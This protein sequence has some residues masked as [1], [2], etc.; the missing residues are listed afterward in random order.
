MTFTR[1]KFFLACAVASSISIS[2]CSNSDN[3]DQKNDTLTATVPAT[4]EAST[5]S[6]RNAQQRLIK[7]LNQHFKTA[8]INA[9]VENIQPT[10]VPNLFWVNIE[11]MPAIYATADG[12]YIIQGDVIRLGDKQPHNVSESLQAAQNKILLSQLKPAD[13]ITYKAK[14][15]T[16]HIIYVFTDVSC[17]YCHK[18]HEHM[19]EINAQGIEVRYIAWPRGEQ[20][21][22]AMETVWCSP[23]RRA[24]FDKAVTGEVLDTISCKNPVAEQYQLGI[25]MGV[26]GTPA[27]Y[28]EN[29]NYLG[30]YLSPEELS[31][32]LNN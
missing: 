10:E 16:K 30:G 24:A 18:L 6:E 20:F 15:Q 29:G 28:D 25:K 19:A 21:I 9:K 31:K 8:G 17:P 13:L 27:I 5:L 3:N 12:K 2:A 23:D 14:G 4:G 7:T 1:S 26:N 32:R 11:G 22:P